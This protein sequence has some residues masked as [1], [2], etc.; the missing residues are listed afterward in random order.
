MWPSILV[1]YA[2]LSRPLTYA[3][4]VSVYALWPTSSA[5]P[6]GV[7]ELL[8]AARSTRKVKPNKGLTRQ[9]KTAPKFPDLLKRD[10]TAAT[11]NS[12]WVGDL[13]EIPTGEGKL[14]MATVTDLCSRKLLAAAVLGASER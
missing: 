10:F 8:G 5:N 14:Y 12:R 13:T 4:L 9:D 7:A 6:Q 1:D 11:I 3:D 2:D